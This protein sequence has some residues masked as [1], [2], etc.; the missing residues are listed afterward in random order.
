MP[1]DTHSNLV[2]DMLRRGVALASRTCARGFH[3]TPIAHRIHP[4]ARVRR[5]A[6]HISGAKVDLA[7]RPSAQNLPKYGGKA[8][9]WKEQRWLDER[10]AAAAAKLDAHHAEDTPWGSESWQNF[11][12][13]TS[14][15]AAR[16]LPQGR[17]GRV[18]TQGAHRSPVRP[19]HTKRGRAR[20]L[21]LAATSPVGQ[22]GDARGSPLH[23]RL[24][25]RCVARYAL[26]ISPAEA[27]SP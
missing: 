24:A 23:G 26:S 19:R 21:A 27:G 25:A 8:P 6:R 4:K 20:P 10:E 16:G 1:A 18:A 5:R 14:Q 22:G 2:S 7:L 9:N 13:F 17:V 15:R 12:M 11:R 3:A